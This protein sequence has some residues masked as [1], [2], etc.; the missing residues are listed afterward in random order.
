VCARRIS[1]ESF[2]A[3]TYD[4]EIRRA[5]ARDESRATNR[6]RRIARDESRATNRAPRIAR[7][8]SRQR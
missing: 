1:N 7:G 3:R 6:A 4:D 2:V 5:L 8:E